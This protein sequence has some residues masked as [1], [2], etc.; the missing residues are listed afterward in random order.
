MSPKNTER[1]LLKIIKEIGAKENINMQLL[2]KDWIIELESDGVY[3]YIFGY[4]FEINSSTAQ[5]IAQDK[6]ATYEVLQSKEI[7]V[8]EHILFMNPSFHKYVGSQGNWQD[9]LTY[10]NSHQ[11]KIVAKPTRGTGGNAVHL[12]DNLVDLEISIHKLFAKNRSIALSPFYEIK[13]EFRVIVLDSEVFVAYFKDIPKVIG[14]GKSSIYELMQLKFDEATIQK[15]QSSSNIKEELHTVLSKNEIRHFHWKH[16]L[17]LTA[18]P[19]I[20]PKT[21]TPFD[22]LAAL[23]IKACSAINIRFASVDIIQVQDTFKVLEINSG[24]MGES[25]SRS[26]KEAYEIMKGAYRKA[27]LKM[28]EKDV[29]P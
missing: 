6:C 9:I 27:I 4:N 3:K 16:N 18:Q 17:G 8:V 14:D 22:E 5:M 24:V 1:N 15:L 20:V 10:F 13:T 11:N 26:S 23:A 12:I 25:F 28:L 29:S 21:Q 2:S 7:P 19:I